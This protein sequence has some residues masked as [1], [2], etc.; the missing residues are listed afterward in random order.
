MK[1]AL[2]TPDGLAQCLLCRWQ[3]R[4]PTKRRDRRRHTEEILTIAARYAALEHDLLLH[5]QSS[6][7][8]VLV[9]KE[10][11]LPASADALPKVYYSGRRTT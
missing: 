1:L 4:A 6:H 3:G 7:D 5:L 9:T 11:I 10:E 8:R 2:I